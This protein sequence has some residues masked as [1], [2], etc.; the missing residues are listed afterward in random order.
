MTKSFGWAK[1]PMIQRVNQLDHNIPITMVYGSR[2]W[3]DISM[4]EKMKE[5]RPCS[6]VDIHLIDKAGHHVYSDQSTIFNNIV[7]QVCDRIE[8]DLHRE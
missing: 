7:V 1:R 5:L 3:M 4:G 8:K 6:Y 2:S